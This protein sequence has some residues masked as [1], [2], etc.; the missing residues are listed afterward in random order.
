MVDWG[1][2]NEMKGLPIT[3]FDKRN[4]MGKRRGKKMSLF[5]STSYMIIY[6]LFMCII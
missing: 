3:M 1:E 5:F 6:K 4:E 2:K